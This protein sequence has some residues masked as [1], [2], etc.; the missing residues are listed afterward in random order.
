VLVGCCVVVVAVL[1]AIVAVMPREERRRWYAALLYFI[2][3]FIVLYTHYVVL[4]IML[5][6]WYAILLYFIQI[7]LYS[8]ALF[9]RM[10]T[11]SGMRACATKRYTS[12]CP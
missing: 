3:C 9:S 7:M 10:H 8:I 2:R 1:V 4:H 5:Y 12:G 11:Y 6:Y